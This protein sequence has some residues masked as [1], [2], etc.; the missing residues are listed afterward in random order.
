MNT[1]YT[2]F[3][4]FHLEIVHVMYDLARQLNSSSH[5]LEALCVLNYLLT[6]SPSNF[7]AKLLCMQIYHRMGCAWAAHK[8][9]ESLGLKFIQLDSMGY[10]HCA[11][12]AVSGIPSLSRSV[13]EPTLKF[14]ANSQKEGHEY[15]SMCYKYGSF[16]KLQEFMDFQERLLNSHHYLL[17]MANAVLLEIV[18]LAGTTDQNLNTLKSLEIDSSKEV[19]QWDKIRDNR[20]LSV[21]VRWDPYQNSAAMTTNENE[22]FKRHI[23]LLQI[24]WTLICLIVLGVE[25]ITKDSYAK[26]VRKDPSI[27]KTELLEQQLMC[28]SH[29][30]SRIREAAWKPS[31]DKFLADPIESRLYGFLQLPYEEIFRNVFKLV[32]SLEN[33]VTDDNENTCKLLEGNISQISKL[34]TESIERHNSSSDVLWDRR[35]VQ[36]TVSNGIEVIFQKK[37]GALVAELYKI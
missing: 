21:I 5:L 11:H 25:S 16:S 36:E 24:R 14:F 27:N 32:L 13:H 33:P 15:L 6:N 4:N 26:N 37:K 3:Q 28:W 7:H 17:T 23:E 29:T 20:D 2:V 18:T 9:Y 35:K 22:S 30:F 12:L 1:N 8:S 31:S 10:L 19:I 34:I